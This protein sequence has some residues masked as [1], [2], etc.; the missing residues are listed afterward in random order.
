MDE[1]F[2]NTKR[3]LCQ[4]ERF[5][6]LRYSGFGLRLGYLLGGARRVPAG[7]VV[8][9]RPRRLV[10]G[11][12][13]AGVALP[14]PPWAVVGARVRERCERRREPS[15]RP[16]AAR[17]VCRDGCIAAVPASLEG[18]QCGEAGAMVRLSLL[19]CLVVL[20]KG[21]GCL[22]KNQKKCGQKSRL[23]ACCATS[24]RRCSFA[25]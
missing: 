23:S 21:P 9:R 10:D 20:G 6:Q 5:I 14:R 2:V 7:H 13:A 16:R 3:V 12:P 18:V 22:K 25:I 24:I 15:R 19:S 8:T 1:A 4:W 11:H 17:C